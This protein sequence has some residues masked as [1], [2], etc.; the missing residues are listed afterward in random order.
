MKVSAIVLDLDGTLLDSHK[1]VSNRNLN[2]VIACH[3]E[4]IPILIATARPPRSVRELL[5]ELLRRIGDIIYYNGALVINESLS[6]KEH[7][8]IDPIVSKEMIDYIITNE[9]DPYLSVEA[10]DSW[11]SN[12]E[13]DYN[14]MMHIQHRPQMISI[15]E[16]KQ[17]E[18]SKILLTHYATIQKLIEQFAHKVNLIVTDSGS[19]IQI[20]SKE[21]SKERAVSRILERWSIPWDEV[22]VFGD[23]FNDL[24]LFQHSRYSIAM[25]NAIKELKDI[26]SEV[27]ESNDSDGVAVVLERLCR[28]VEKTPP[29]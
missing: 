1:K 22:M 10:E 12:R 4:G 13:L 15:E 8:P 16:M 26:A 24:G 25:G 18:A 23:D 5:P 21:A 20:S 17:L 2:A 27:T 14:E 29:H 3:N 6:L 19:L 11:F 28:S 7:Y 9:S